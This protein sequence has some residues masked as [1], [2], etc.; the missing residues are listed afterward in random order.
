MNEISLK[1]QMSHWQ[2]TNKILARTVAR[3]ICDLSQKKLDNI[4]TRTV[5]KFILKFLKVFKSKKTKM[6]IF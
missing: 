6:I 4:L 3:S 2:S 5:V 1:K